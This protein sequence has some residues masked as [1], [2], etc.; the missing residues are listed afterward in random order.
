MVKHGSD[1][2]DLIDPSLYTWSYIKC[3]TTSKVRRQRIKLRRR[4]S[5]VMALSAYYMKYGER[6]INPIHA[7]PKSILN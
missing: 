4:A 2:K 7:P 5:N 3:A 1:R 6:K